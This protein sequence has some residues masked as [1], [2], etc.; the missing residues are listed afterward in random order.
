MGDRIAN[1]QR[2]P[3]TYA[4]IGAAMA[5]HARL[6]HGFLESVYQEA[7]AAELTRRHV[8]FEREVE[9]EVWDAG[10]IL[11]SHFRADFIAYRSVIIELKAVGALNW[12]HGR[13]V[14]N[15]LKATGIRIGLLLNFGRPSLEWKR[16]IQSA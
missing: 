7:L 4:I 1:V 11:D 3:K 9:I 10:K 15:D 2:D 8:P 13:Q 6:G 16:L 5:V 14:I 12:G